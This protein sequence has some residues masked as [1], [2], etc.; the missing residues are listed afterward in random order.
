MVKFRIHE[1]IRCICRIRYQSGYIYLNHHDAYCKHN[2][3]ALIFNTKHMLIH[4][5]ISNWFLFLILIRFVFLIYLPNLR[6]QTRNTNKNTLP[7]IYV[8]SPPH[9]SATWKK[10]SQEYC[11]RSTFIL[12]IVYLPYSDVY[13]SPANGVCGLFAFAHKFTNNRRLY[14]AIIN[15]TQ[16]HPRSNQCHLC[17]TICAF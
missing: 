4:F 10:F 3:D 9:S 6:L 7:N 17:Q 2:R 16:L 14:N 1:A 15:Q 13:S 5:F 11:F 8:Y 12:N